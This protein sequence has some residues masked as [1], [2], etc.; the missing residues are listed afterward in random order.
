MATE[1]VWLDNAKDDVRA[2]LHFIALDNPFA[3]NR[4]V[5]DLADACQR[6]SEFPLSGRRYNARFRCLTFRNHLVFYQFDDAVERVRI[7]AVIDGRR[8]IKGLVGVSD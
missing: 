1:V 4:Y 6:L 3:A 7:V 2:I 8:D 5:T